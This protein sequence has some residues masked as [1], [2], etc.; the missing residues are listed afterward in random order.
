ML[1]EEVGS[2]TPFVISGVQRDVHMLQLQATGCIGQSNKIVSG[3]FEEK[4][5][6]YNVN[7]NA[8]LIE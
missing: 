7:M 8:T 6:C 3:H 2:I 1:T 5:F 4:D